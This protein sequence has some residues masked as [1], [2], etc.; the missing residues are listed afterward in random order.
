MLDNVPEVTQFPMVKQGSQRVPAGKQFVIT[1]PVKQGSFGVVR[2]KAMFSNQPVWKGSQ[3]TQTSTQQTQQ[4]KLTTQSIYH[5]SENKTEEN[6]LISISD[7]QQQFSEFYKMNTFGDE[8][9]QNSFPNYQIKLQPEPLSLQPE[10]KREPKP[11]RIKEQ[12]P[13]I[14]SKQPSEEVK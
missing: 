13:L 11:Q 1:P 8:A 2:S 6:Q 4:M 3:N 10:D 9:L 5:S 12:Y 14:I 7:E